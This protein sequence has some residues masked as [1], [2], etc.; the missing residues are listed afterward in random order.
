MRTLFAIALLSLASAA[1]ACPLPPGVTEAR[2][3]PVIRGNSSIAA[4]FPLE[5]KTVPIYALNQEIS[6]VFAEDTGSA[7]NYFLI[8][9]KEAPCWQDPVQ[10]RKYIPNIEAVSKRPRARE[11]S[12]GLFIILAGG[13]YESSFILEP[14]FLARVAKPKAVAVVVGVP[15]RD[16]LLFAAPEDEV[17]VKALREQVDR[18]Y[19]GA[20]KVIS[21]KP[22]RLEPGRIVV[23][24]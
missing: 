16:V 6:V 23:L 7:I 3:V 12:P 18:V 2:V 24:D 10:L 19:Q 17:A 14:D 22:M 9:T 1:H 8:P 21:N 20:D 15:A 13:N 4:S 11:I 5:P